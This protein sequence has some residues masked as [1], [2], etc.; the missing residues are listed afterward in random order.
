MGDF[1][2][3]YT[4]GWFHFYLECLH[5]MLFQTPV[6]IQPQVIYNVLQ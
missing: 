1:N 5:L 4:D 6:I 3:A 2:I